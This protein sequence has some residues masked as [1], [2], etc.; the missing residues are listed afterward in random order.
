M[1]E[2]SY[3]LAQNSNNVIYSCDMIRLKFFLDEG[4]DKHVNM[5]E[6]DYFMHELFKFEVKYFMSFSVKSYRH[7]YVFTSRDKK[8]V[9]TLGLFHNSRDKRTGHH[10]SFIEF[11]PNKMDVCALQYLFDFL[12]LNTEIYM[13]FKKSTIFEV[14]RW[15]LAVDIPISRH[16]VRLLKDGKRKYTRVEEHSSITEYSGKRNTDGFVKVY[17]KTK[18]S[19]LYYDLTRIEITNDSFNLKLPEVYLLQYQTSLDFDFNL[20]ATDKVLVEL[21]RRQED[22]DVDYWLRQLGKDKRKKLKPYIFEP[23]Q[24]FEFDKKAIYHVSTVVE[25]ICNMKLQGGDYDKSYIKNTKQRVKARK[26]CDKSASSGDTSWHEISE[27]EFKQHELDYFN[28]YNRG[29]VGKLDNNV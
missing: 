19:D 24:F 29:S 5:N 18:E 22:C 20:N 7:L 2:L 16:Y 26:Q 8:C 27:E 1:S 4:F 23:K 10:A 14:V 6:C 13:D 21:I 17:D 15:D 3:Y 28:N 25:D 12:C 11:N 9:I